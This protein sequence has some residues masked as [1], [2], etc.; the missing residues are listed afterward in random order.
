MNEFAVHR[1]INLGSWCVLE[2]DDVL[3]RLADECAITPWNMCYEL[4][5]HQQGAGVARSSLLFLFL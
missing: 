5:H 3:E 2:R 4:L 1:N